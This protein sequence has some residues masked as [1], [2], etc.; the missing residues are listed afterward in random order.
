MTLFPLRLERLECPCRCAIDWLTARPRMAAAALAALALATYLPGLLALPPVDR[1]EVVYAE[2]AR[3]M[4]EHGHPS[5]A[6]FHGERYPFRPI[7]IT[8]LQAATGKLLGRSAQSAIAIYRLPSLIGGLLAV[9][10]TFW[11]LG[12]LIGERRAL[13]SSALFAVTPI[14][15]LQAELAIPEGPQ[16]LAIVLAQLTLLR[17]YCGPDTK[18]ATRLAALFW[19]AQGFGM[20][21]NALAVPILS[22]ATILALYV[23]DRNLR[24]LGRLRPLLGLPLTALIAAPWLLVRAHVDGGVPFATLSWHDF[25][26]ALGG[27]QHMKWKAAPFTFTVAFVLG[28]LPGA[29]L[30]VPAIKGLWEARAAALQRFLFCWLAGYLA[31]LE[32]ISSKPA[33]YTVEALFPAAAA[34]AAL[35]LEK[36][37]KLALPDYMLRPPAWLVAAFMA[38]LIVGILYLEPTGRVVIVLAMLLVTCLFTLAAEAA[39]ARLAALWLT[40][41]VAGFALFLAFTFAVVLPR[42]ERVWPATRIAAAIAPF[43]HCV[44]GPVG[45]VGLREPST[46]FVLGPDSEVNPATVADRMAGGEDGIAIVEDR[47]HGDLVRALEERHAEIPEPAGCVEAFN[48]MRGCPLSFS[49]YITGAPRLDPECRIAPRYACKG[50]P[51]MTPAGSASRCR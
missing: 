3:G 14:V 21:L 38:A 46:V 13:I 5:D 35:S 47:W 25:I 23:F 10:A 6:Q 22:A 50:K 51:P 27:A 24:W 48:V 11:L 1:T 17:L 34:A 43:E 28:F 8:W 49:I 39:R 36:D 26:R 33:L 9:L 15:A 7:G 16:L 29:L 32:L 4:L 37:G 41:S 20:L 44:V 45:V 12:P 18:S 2:M 40:S 42:I 19:A 30:L 31:Y